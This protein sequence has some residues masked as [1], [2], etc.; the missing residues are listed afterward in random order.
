MIMPGLDGREV[1]AGFRAA[2]PGIPVVG[3]TGFAGESDQDTV[4]EQ[5]GL[6]GL[7]TKP[8]SADALIRAVASACEGSAV[9]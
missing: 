1:A 8:F 5:A 4:V 6:A 3:I 2:R 9:P 7:V